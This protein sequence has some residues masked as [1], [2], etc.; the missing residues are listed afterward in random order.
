[1][2][3]SRESGHFE[4]AIDPKWY[5]VTGSKLSHDSL[6]ETNAMQISASL[7]LFRK[8]EIKAVTYDAVTGAPQTV[9]DD[10]D[11]NLKVWII[12]PKFE[13]PILN[14]TNQ[15][16]DPAGAASTLPTYGSAS[17]PIGMWHQYGVLPEDESTGIFMEIM[18]IPDDFILSSS[19][20]L[21]EAPY[22]G[23]DDKD[24]QTMGLGDPEQFRTPI[25]T[26][27]GSRRYLGLQRTGSLCELVGFP[28][29]PV[30]LGVPAA[31]KTVSEAIVAVPFIEKDSERM[32]F[33]IERETVDKAEAELA[34]GGA[35]SL[36]NQANEPG[37]TI[38]NMITSMKK[39]VIPPKM[40]YL[41]N[42]EVTPFAMYIFEFEHEFKQKD[43]T[44]IWQNLPPDSIERFSHKTVTIS[45]ELL[46]TELMGQAGDISGKRMQNNLQWMVFKVKQ[47]A[48]KSY[49]SK[50]AG[51]ATEEQ[52]QGGVFSS[53]LRAG[54]KY[55]FNLTSGEGVNSTQTV[56]TYSYN[57]PYDYFSLIELAQIESTVTYGDIAIPG[58]TPI[59]R[60]AQMGKINA[61]AAGVVP[62]SSA[63]CVREGTIIRTERGE[64]PV[65]EILMTDKVYGYQIDDAELGFFELIDIFSFI[66][67][68]WC[69]IKTN[70]GKELECSTSHNF[71]K[72]GAET[73]KITA[74]D[75]NIGSEILINDD[76]QL[77]VDTVTEI[78]VIQEP[79]K[80]WN[81]TVDKAHTYFSNGMLSHNAATTTG[82]SGATYS[83]GG[84]R[85][86]STAMP[87]FGGAAQGAVAAASSTGS[88]TGMT[89]AGLGTSAGAQ[90]S[91][92]QTTVQS[93]AGYSMTQA[94]VF[95]ATTSKTST[96][97]RISSNMGNLKSFAGAAFGS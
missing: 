52:E 33:H 77:V 67:P 54:F 95:E 96:S 1:L 32:F 2:T 85:T 60:L 22:Y 97:S 37:E 63:G 66:T 81:F 57:W 58:S 35:Y 6:N 69:K 55:N 46:A 90:S 83:T 64:I 10:N 70:S 53:A 4:E 75:I 40:D 15:F 38:L 26:G 30:K 44:D 23:T 61:L 19:T 73:N 14:F 80:V 89:T 29:T 78:E 91:G 87:S 17:T 13:T 56:P 20:G 50:I 93:G 25:T 42:R 76:G 39:F 27:Q 12:Q 9:S 92:A 16:E 86:A 36:A 8:A 94:G 82:A 34:G 72:R 49:A 24:V 21:G 68:S 5:W 28:T 59:S 62:V 51:E 65:E 3:S 7:N 41:T 31:T 18:D 43:L 88:S 47:K 48:N 79:V 71:V 45:H 84:G 74:S 11:A